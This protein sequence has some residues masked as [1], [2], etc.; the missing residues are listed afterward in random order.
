MLELIEHYE[1]ILRLGFFLGILL[2]IAS[3]EVLS[4]R[5]QLRYS[6]RFRW[7]NNLG[8]VVLNTILL[9][10]VF[11]TATVGMALLANERGWGFLSLLDLPLWLALVVSLVI[12]DFMIWL[13]HV[14]VHAIPVLWRLHRVH[15]ADPDYDVTTGLRFHPLEI[16]LSMVIKFVVIAAMGPPVVAVI[17][18]EIILNGMAMFNHGNIRLPAKLDRVLRWLVVTPDMH[19]VHHSVVDY[20][21]NSNFG[22]N[23]SLWDR[24]FGTYIAQPREGHDGIKIGISGFD[25]PQQVVRLDGL[26]SLPFKGRAGEYVINRRSWDGHDK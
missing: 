26:L 22:F 15:H 9:R 20:E 18:F 12:L 6:R 16:L 17:L 3:W 1:G 7:L 23:L 11:P 8:L 14:T 5:R 10:L 2:L 21:T 4:P 24:L 25:Q 19:R 13:Q